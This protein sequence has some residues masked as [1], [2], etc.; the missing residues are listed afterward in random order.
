MDPVTLDM[1]A[2]C[3]LTDLAE[4]PRLLQ[5]AIERE[6]DIEAELEAM[7]AKRQA[8][9]LRMVELSSTTAEVR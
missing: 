2:L 4:V 5:A 7:L 8:M 3:R 1:E 9:Q 6:R